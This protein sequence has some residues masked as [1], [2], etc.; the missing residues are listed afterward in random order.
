MYIREITKKLPNDSRKARKNKFHLHI[1]NRSI[2]RHKQNPSLILSIKGDHKGDSKR[3]KC[4]YSFF[5]DSN[6]HFSPSLLY[7]LEFPLFHDFYDV[8]V[9]MEFCMWNTS[10]YIK[11]ISVMI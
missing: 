2:A 9:K 4:G 1:S 3:L 6:N 7:F 10:I 11:R 5:Y 8:P